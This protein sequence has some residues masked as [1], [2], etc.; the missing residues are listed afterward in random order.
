MQG[1]D[2]PAA[3]EKAFTTENTEK[4]GENPE[5]SLFYSKMSF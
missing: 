2:L 4:R 5:I 3:P 1:P